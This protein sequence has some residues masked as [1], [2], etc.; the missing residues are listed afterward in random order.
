MIS[1]NFRAPINHFFHKFGRVI[2]KTGVTPNTL[3]FLGLVFVGLACA[4]FVYNENAFLFGFS[5]T[6]TLLFDVLDGAVARVTQNV[7]K[8]GGY[9]DAVIDRYQ[10]VIIFFNHRLC[11]RTLVSRLFGHYRVSSNQLQQSQSWHGSSHFKY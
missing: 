10:E 4:V 11:D 6:L 9:F 1:G 7:S 8:F 5:L 2:A 3:T